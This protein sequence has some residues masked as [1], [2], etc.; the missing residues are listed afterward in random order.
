[1][2]RQGRW[3]PFERTVEQAIL[4]TARR[5]DEEVVLEG[6]AWIGQFG[7][8][9]E[10]RR[11]VYRCI[12][13]LLQLDD[14]ERDVGQYNETLSLLFGEPTLRQATALVRREQPFFGLNTLGANMEGSEMHQRLL[15]AYQ[16]VQRLKGVPLN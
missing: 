5:G 8:L 2:V 14:A 3:E 10:Q 15:G 7:V 12:E 6:C 13:N 11:R 16:K 9:S 1:M 4:S